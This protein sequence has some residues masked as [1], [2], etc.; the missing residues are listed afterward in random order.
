M[1]ATLLVGAGAGA[2]F[3]AGTAAVFLAVALTEMGLEAEV[4]LTFYRCSDVKL[5]GKT[6]E[7]EKRKGR[8]TSF[9]ATGSL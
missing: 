2:A 3:L 9:P 7:E 1:A 4:G 6:V 5:E 8:L